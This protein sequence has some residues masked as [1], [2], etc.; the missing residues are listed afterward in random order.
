M[1]P[2]MALLV[3]C[4]AEPVDAS[5]DRT[6]YLAVLGERT[7]DPAVGLE[8]CRSIRDETLAGDCALHV[9][10]VEARRTGGRPAQWCEAV[11]RGAWRDECWF[12]SA[13]AA[14]RARNI[15]EA[16]RF[17]M[18][19]GAFRD[20]CAQHLWQS[21][22]HG[23]IHRQGSRAFAAVL[24]RV[25]AVYERWAPLLAEQSDF[26]ARFWAKFFQNGFEGQG[27]FVDLS[28]CDTLADP[29]AAR[30]VQAGVEMY[31]RELAPRLSDAQMEICSLPEP[32]NGLWSQALLP[33]VPTHPDARLD[34]VVAARRAQCD[35]AG[36]SSAPL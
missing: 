32:A 25:E 27:G 10:M 11:P 22:V 17:C 28:H 31:A 5:G 12:V 20:D 26:D 29:Y 21:E 13:E 16:A 36:A 23:L 1:P 3:G 4:A 30:C 6:T 35:A 9:V 14:K 34:A 7:I 24:P 15:E 8:T 33:S 19:A 2:A 18:E